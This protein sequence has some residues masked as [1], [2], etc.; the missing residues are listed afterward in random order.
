[1][2]KKHLRRMLAGGMGVLATAG[3]GNSLQAQSADALIDKLVEKGILS[4]KEANEMREE[5]DKNFTTAYQVKSG[6]SDWV[7]SFRI[8][9]DLRGRFD[10]Q[11]SSNPNFV[12]RDRWRYRLRVGATAVIKD[13]FEVGMRLGSGDV[14]NAAG[15]TAGVDPISQNQSFQN[16]ASKKGIF[17]D[18]A[19]A[20]WTPINNRDW[21]ASLTVG[22]I[23]NP[24]VFSDMVFDPDYTPEGASQQIAYNLSAKQVLKLNLGE[25]VLDELGGSTQDPYLLG[26][27]LGLESTWSK[28]VA[29][30]VGVGFL[31]ITSS[32]QL[33]S[34]AVPYINRGNLRYVGAN[35]ILGAP[36][37]GFNSLIA[38]AA[39]TYTLDS[40]PL[41]TGAFPIRPFGEF[42]HNTANSEQ[43]NGYNVGITFG[44]AGKKGTWEVTYRYKYLGGDAWWEQLADSDFGAFYQDK[45]VA[46]LPPT[47]R[48]AASGYWPGTNVR[49]HIVK[50]SYSPYD[51]LTFNVTWFAAEL[52]Q[53][54]N[55]GTDSNMN[56]IQVDAV[57]KF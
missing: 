4:V 13:N 35:G 24:F 28:K 52:I 54:Q 47:A 44:K 39:M 55:P 23:E 36:V 15:L 53:E 31:G 11:Y 1:M 25:F 40:F 27:Q 10:G 21:S 57:W 56:R 5:T 16:N 6:M 32:Q 22:K 38:S 29:T 43:N 18:L 33:T 42:I 12:E 14:D 7:T 26:G 34:T 50:A 45:L 37:H 46:L 2:K 3:L 48:A 51:S 17:L 19:Y 9:G 8:N 20:K 30:S 41:Y 49:G